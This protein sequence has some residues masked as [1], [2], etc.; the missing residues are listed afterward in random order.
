MKIGQVFRSPAAVIAV[1]L[2]A[3]PILTSLAA[4]QSGQA[5]VEGVKGAAHYSTGQEVWLPLKAHTLLKPG[6]L[7]RTG[8]ES[9]VRLVF[10]DDGSVITANPNTVIRIARISSTETGLELVS[11]TDLE[12][13]EGSLNGTQTK[14]SALSH[15]QINVRDGFA[16]L[17]Q[18]DYSINADGPLTILRGLIPFQYDHIALV[19][20]PQNLTSIT[21]SSETFEIASTKA[22][23][24]APSN[25]KAVS[26]HGNNGVG[27][28]IDPAPPGNPK[29][30]DGPGT[31]PGNPGNGP[32]K[33]P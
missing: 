19:V 31:S 13:I 29:P 26:Q 17:E 7:I 25:E 9:T 14:N 16:V 21:A 8:Q 1:V 28:G 32:P 22:R 15:F 6:T 24:L 3:F 23:A 27:N 4:K 5:R 10:K 33:R 30:N 20:V 2:T 18:S 11:E 12:L